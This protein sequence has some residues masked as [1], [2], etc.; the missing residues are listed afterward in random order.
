MQPGGEKPFSRGLPLCLAE[1]CILMSLMMVIHGISFS[2][3][4]QPC[5]RNVKPR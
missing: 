3:T 4:L 2:N 5:G 1:S